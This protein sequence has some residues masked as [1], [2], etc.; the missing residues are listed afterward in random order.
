VKDSLKHFVK[1]GK[2]FSFDA[3]GLRIGE[4]SRKGEMISSFRT[5]GVSRAFSETRGLMLGN[6]STESSPLSSSR[7]DGDGLISMGINKRWI[8]PFENKGEW[9]TLPRPRRSLMGTTTGG[10]ARNT[11]GALGVAIGESKAVL[12]M[13]EM[14][15]RCSTCEDFKK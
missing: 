9:S 8:G 14:F 7:G 4:I 1:E 13:M 3:G 10:V 2:L 5:L 6:D 11:S 12:V 15:R